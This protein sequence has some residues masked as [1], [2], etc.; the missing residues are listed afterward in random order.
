[1]AGQGAYGPATRDA[2]SD[3]SPPARSNSRHAELHNAI[4]MPPAQRGTDPLTSVT[5]AGILTM[6][7]PESGIMV[8]RRRAARARAAASSGQPPAVA[9]VHPGPRIA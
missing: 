1:M 5:R 6:T 8:M 3:R 4:T 9:L 7:C 2:A